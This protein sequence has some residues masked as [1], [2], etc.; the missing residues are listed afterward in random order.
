MGYNVG[1]LISL[2][3]DCCKKW[4]T[5]G[6]GNRFCASNLY[7]SYHSASSLFTF[8]NGNSAAGPCK[9]LGL[10]HEH[11]GALPD[12]LGWWGALSPTC[13]WFGGCPLIPGAAD[14]RVRW[15][16][17][18]AGAVTV[19]VTPALD[20][21]PASGTWWREKAAAGSHSCWSTA[22][23]VAPHNPLWSAG[24]IRHFGIELQW[25]FKN[26]GTGSKYNY[27]I[28]VTKYFYIL[29][30]IMHH[31][32]MY[33]LHTSIVFIW[34]SGLIEVIWCLKYSNTV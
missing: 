25:P 13:T 23:S 10:V 2:F 34:I 1:G 5:A 26:T 20:P 6:I 29:L 12:A 22:G 32:N 17:A 9:S 11:T 14:G 28:I 16:V 8:C 21:Q 15:G 31:V 27:I 19:T 30:I 33:L 7:F 4:M 3:I 24:S 18:E